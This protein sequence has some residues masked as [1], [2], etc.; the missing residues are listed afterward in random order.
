MYHKSIKLTIASFL[1]LML[2]FEGTAQCQSIQPA[3]VNG[4]TYT[5]YFISQLD[6]FSTDI[7]F[8]DKGMM[9]LTKY[10]GNGFYFTLTD[11]FM[12]IYWSLNQT[13]G[14]RTGDYIFIISGSTKDPF[15][16][17]I[18]IMIYEY[19]EFFLSLFFGFRSV[20]TE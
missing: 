18:C 9:E 7:I 19:K 2:I 11:L 5:C 8:D 13:I 16:S 17:G 14:L 1:L 4:N 3:V 15:I 12:G 10:N 6:I 20:S